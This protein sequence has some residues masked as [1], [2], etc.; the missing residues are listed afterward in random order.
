MILNNDNEKISEVLKGFKAR[1]ISY[2]VD[3][4]ADWQAT[5]VEKGKHGQSV[6]ILHNNIINNYDIKRF[7]RHHVYALLTELV[8]QKNINKI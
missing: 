6:K 7:G 2:G 5:E 1:K 8:V 4:K 3:N